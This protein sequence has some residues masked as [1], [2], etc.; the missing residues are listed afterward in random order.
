MDTELVWLAPLVRMKMLS[1]TRNASSVR[2]N[3]ATRMAGLISGTVTIQ[4]RFQ[5]E[6]PSI[7]AALSRSSGTRARPAIS[8]SAMN[9]TVF[10]TSARMMIAIEGPNEVNGAESFGAS[11]PRSWVQAKRQENAAT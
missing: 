9:G 6:A 3:S 11:Q 7:E 5:A 1:K 2:N 4:K 8:S 10:Q